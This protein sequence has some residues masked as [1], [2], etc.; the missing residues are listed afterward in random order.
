[1]GDCGIAPEESWSEYDWKFFGD[2]APKSK[3]ITYEKIFHAKSITKTIIIKRGS[4]NKFYIFGN[5]HDS[6][7]E[8]LNSS[9]AFVLHTAYVL[10]V[11]V[12]VDVIELVAEEI[13]KVFQFIIYR[14]NFKRFA[15]Q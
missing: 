3:V 15:K 7:V 12:H 14:L 9:D 2:D 1:M 10:P 11:F 13:N 5:R 8:A 4:D 6:F